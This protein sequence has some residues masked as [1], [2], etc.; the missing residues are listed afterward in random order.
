[1]LEL[2]LMQRTKW[3]FWKNERKYDCHSY[4][5][6]QN[7]LMII[8]VWFNFVIKILISDTKFWAVDR[9]VFLGSTAVFISVVRAAILV[10][11]FFVDFG[12]TL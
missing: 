6:S 4:S 7:D 9:N 1:M 8:T 12:T 11:I 5:T 3:D 2:G 10:A